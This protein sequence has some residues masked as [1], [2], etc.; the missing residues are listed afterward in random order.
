MPVSEYFHGKGRKVMKDMQAR[1][2]EKKGKSVFY[3]K[4]NKMKSHMPTG[5]SMKGAWGDVGMHRQH[6]AMAAGGFSSGH[7]IHV[8]EKFPC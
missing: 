8:K 6:E 4:V 3:A 7:D 1:Y 5:A 2:G